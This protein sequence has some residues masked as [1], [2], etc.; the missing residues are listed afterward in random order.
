MT[1]MERV[2]LAG[3][4]RLAIF[5]RR[6]H[7]AQ[8][9]IQH[10]R[11]LGV[12]WYLAFSG[13][14]D[15]TVLLDLLWQNSMP[16]D[17]RWSDDGFDFPE[18]LTFLQETEARLNAPLHRVRNMHS[19]RLWCEEMDRTD[20]VA[21]PAAL[22]AWGNPHAWNSV[23]EETMHQEWREY[24]GVFLGLLASESRARGY[25]LKGGS[26]PL[27]QVKSEHD[28]WHCSPLAHWTKRDV[29]SYVASRDL[30]YNPVYD[31]LAECGIPL[32]YRRV[33]PL[34]CYRTMQYGSHVAL[35]TAW[36]D[37]YN[38]LCVLFPDVRASV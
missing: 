31:R 32:E 17:L 33:A 1:P 2:A 29:W 21:D 28:M 19:W 35:K 25:A 24:G 16:C 23:R 8:Q 36:P 14:V 6:L 10:A 11:D 27:Y 22:T 12:R 34:T 38:R 9:C 30:A 13:G 37:L 26:Q 15:S 4:S 7:E 18:T 3:Y 20:L 5:E